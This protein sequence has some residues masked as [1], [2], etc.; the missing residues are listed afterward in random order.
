[1][2]YMDWN[3][4]YS[5]GIK[6][7]DDQHKKLFEIL[8]NLHEAMKA[9]QSK[10]VLEKVIIELSNYTIYHF[11]TE[12]NF[13]KNHQYSAYVAHKGEHDKFVLK[14]VEYKNKFTKSSTITAIEMLTFL[15]NWLI[16]HV[17]GT[18]KKYS[19]FLIDKGVK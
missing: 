5:V 19:A 2:A 18:D 7:I 14:V 1:M 11:S 8:N 17:K 6:S 9:G 15:K 16:Q 10:G 3:E 12:E 13:M 4:I